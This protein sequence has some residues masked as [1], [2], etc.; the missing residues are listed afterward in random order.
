MANVVDNLGAEL[1]SNDVASD[2]HIGNE[3]R[4]DLITMRHALEHF[5]DPVAVL[6]K[7]SV[8]LSPRGLVYV[9]V[10]NMMSPTR[11]ALSK[12]W[13]RV[14]HTYYFSR[15]TLGR[16]LA[17]AGLGPFGE[18]CSE[19]SEL[20]GVFRKG[21]IRVDDTSVYAAQMKTIRSHRRRQLI[22]KP[23]ALVPERLI[24][25]VPRGIKDRVKG[26]L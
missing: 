16:A 25:L 22:R 23:R 13:F 24:S 1:I 20:W 3:G 15:A 10:P 18:I 19:G 11:H 12:S 2:W 4:F 7:V 17:M 8:A 6:K 14:V 5:L 9:S 21:S 26:L